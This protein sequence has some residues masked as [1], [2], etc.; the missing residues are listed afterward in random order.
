MSGKTILVGL[1]E[2]NFDFLEYYF[3]QGKLPH[4]K[5]LFQQNR[6]I[7]TISESEYHLLEPWI[8]WVTIHTGK[9]YADH[10]IFRLGDIS[11]NLHL[12]QIFEELEAEGKTVGAMSPFNAANKLKQASFFVPDPWTKTKVTGNSFVQKLYQA[13]HQAVNDNAQEKISASSI[14]T[15]AKAFLFYVPLKNWPS[16]FSNLLNR[17]KPGTKAMI[18]DSLLADVFM[19]LWN[20]HQPDFANLFLNSGAH[21]Q[22]HYMFNSAAYEGPLTNPEWYC[23]K[24]YDPFI[25]VMSIYDK[26]I[27]RLMSKKDL[28]LLV[29]TG[30]HQHPHEHL[31]YYYRIKD[32]D[33]F[34]KALGINDYIE[35]QPRMSR[36]FLII[37]DNE[38]KA[39]K[40]TK[41]LAALKCKQDDEIIFDVDNR[42][43]SLF[44]ELIYPN[45]AQEGMTLTATDLGITY[46]NFDKDISFVAIK[47]GE[48]NGIGYLLSN[49]ELPVEDK[50]PLTQVKDIIKEVVLS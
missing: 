23:P 34:I 27:G 15:L 42:G 5:A 46:Q 41:I 33:A 18:L 35:I 20:K 16:Y 12:S 36:D 45:E 38:Q 30:L 11:E 13:I 8:Q 32:H 21:I 29:A 47:N 48:H 19:K 10:K 37:F 3:A 39:A 17:K 31:T 43:Q 1:N 2:I 24:D 6:R 9:A 25:K 14:L 22:H 50:I 26:I 4:F 40:A 44:I 49:Q 28:K 7:E